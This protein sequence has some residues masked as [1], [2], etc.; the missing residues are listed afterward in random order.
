MRLAL[1]I[2]IVM[3]ASCPAWAAVEV[4]PGLSVQLYVT[5]EG[6]D[7]TET[8]A[9]PGIPAASTLAFD[10]EGILYLARSGRRYMGG[11]V[12][13]K[14]PVYRI[15]VGGA[16]LTRASE[17]RY[18]HGPPLPNPQVGVARASRELFV[19][20]FDRD[21]RIGV[22]YRM[23]DG[24]AELFA[25]GTPDPGRS[26]DLT[27]PEGVALDPGGGFFVADR[28]RGVIVRIDPTGK[29][30]DPRYA[31]M[32]RPR[33]LAA[34]GSGGLWV[35]CDAAAEAPWQPGPGEIWHVS[36][37]GEPRL[38]L[39]GPVP[40]AISLSPG[41][42]LLVADRQGAQVFALAP[43]G[44]RIDLARFTDGDAPRGL[45][46]APVTPETRRAG[47]AG[48]LFVIT[49]NRGTWP[50]NEVLRISG[51]IDEVLRERRGPRP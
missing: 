14:F 25:G 41:G 24:R 35:G 2:V 46:F 6:F 10:P 13:D 12:E 1:V 29:V 37:E 47:I 19:T 3:L 23:V 11:E 17:S 21:R 38:V 32:R 4:P 30:A 50:L 7:S 8:R 18:L 48:D 31:E 5:G 44:T 27:Q 45:V 20:T 15:P 34:D 22:L 51:P 40:Q 39:R 9:A 16:R 42:H 28:A 33:L 26:P 43:D 49:I 36:R